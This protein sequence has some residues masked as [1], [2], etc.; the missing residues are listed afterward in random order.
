MGRCENDLELQVKLGGTG[1]MYHATGP[2]LNTQHARRV[3]EAGGGER[4]RKGEGKRKE[5]GGGRESVGI[6]HARGP[7]FN[8]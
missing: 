6:D 2:R 5:E 4:G 3:I 7:R 1:R 8:T